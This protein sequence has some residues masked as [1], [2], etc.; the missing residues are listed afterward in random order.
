MMVNA[1]PGDVIAV[2][3]PRGGYVRALLCSINHRYQVGVLRSY[4]P[5]IS[6]PDD[7]ADPV[8]L[9]EFYRIDVRRVELS[10]IASGEWPVI[11]RL[12]AFDSE[13]WGQFEF[14]R[15][16]PFRRGTVVV[17]YDHDDPTR[18]LGERN[19][20]PAE[21]VLPTDALAGWR[22]YQ[23]DLE[24]WLLEKAR[25]DPESWGEPWR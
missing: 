3:M 15:S 12:P 20:S 9:D 5:R 14:V 16:E 11:T 2:E 1:K 18:V 7:P 17:S 13:Q 10:K 8:D 19:A 24:D 6:G 25:A 22:A 21:V 23:Y 4:G